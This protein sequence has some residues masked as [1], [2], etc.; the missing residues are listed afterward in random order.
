MS[1]PLQPLAISEP[2]SASPLPHLEPTQP[3]AELILASPVGSLE[4]ARLRSRPPPWEE[5]NHRFLPGSP[6]RVSGV[7]FL[8]GYQPTA[9]NSRKLGDKG[10]GQDILFPW[11][12]IRHRGGLRDWDSEGSGFRVELEF[13][14]SGLPAESG[15]SGPVRSDPVLP[16]WALPSPYPAWLT[17]ETTLCQLSQ[18]SF[19]RMAVGESPGEGLFISVARRLGEGDT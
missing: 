4:F 9:R 3:I 15:Q 16:G 10:R 14:R 1:Q 19:V 11:R 2:P 8:Q 17:R 6:T 12:H 5:C 13:Q 7:W 18:F